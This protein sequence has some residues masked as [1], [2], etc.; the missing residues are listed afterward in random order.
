MQ[1]HVALDEAGFAVAVWHQVSAGR[2]SVWGNRL[3]P[4][5]GG[6]V[7]TLLETDD[8]GDASF[9]DVAVEKGGSATAVWMQNVSVFSIFASRFEPGRGWGRP[10]LIETDDAGHA[11]YPF[12]AVDAVGNAI[13]VWS[14]SDGTRQNV[15]ANRYA[16]AAGWGSATLLE[17]DNAGSAF[18]P[19]VAFDARGDAVVVWY[20]SDGTRTNIWANR[21]SVGAGWAAAELVEND[22]AG[23]AVDPQVALDPGGNAT[24]VWSQSDGTRPNIWA[25][26]YSVGSGWG[27]P[28]L[29]ETDNAGW[30]SRPSVGVDAS[31]VARVVWSQS[32]FF[33]YS[34]WTNRFV[35]GSGWGTRALVETL[36]SGDAYYPRI[37]VA[38]TGEAAAVWQQSDGT[39]E[40]IWANRFEPSGGWGQ[41]QLLEGDNG[42]R[43]LIP[44][45]AGNARGDAVAVW[46]Q[47]VAGIEHIFANA[48]TAADLTAPTLT[49]ESPAEGTL[50]NRSSLWV[51]GRTEPGALTSVN[52]VE[53]FVSAN[54]SFALT[55]PLAPG[56][57]TLTVA[58]RDAYGNEATASVNVTFD[59]PVPGLEARLRQA[60]ADLV[61]ART[62]LHA[63]RVQLAEAE[64]SGN[65]T[66]A[67]LAAAR[68]QFASA[69]ARAASLASDLNAT[70]A[71]L[72]SSQSDLHDATVRLLVV[73]GEVS[74]LQ[75]DLAA[76]RAREEELGSGLNLAN[77]VATAAVGLALGSLGVLAWVARSKG[78]AGGGNP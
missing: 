18:W 1:P 56:P 17:T 15:W 50:T 31:G 72:A 32:N 42:G 16:Q 41:A 55:V 54:G 40:N 71:G 62:D 46:Y 22:D 73:E 64:A 44:R 2:A 36:D 8:T 19:Q 45:V 11:Y 61:A 53:A 30:A 27:S 35:P 38:P 68:A 75:G 10:V 13:A 77:G 14:Q 33:R 63:T 7:P 66:E 29:V 65:A 58:A 59:D 69:E 49:L 34:I 5:V 70:R 20:Q 67:D 4:G 57:N 78:R 52:G 48:Y 76:A 21:Y 43:A 74:A 39:R 26:R 60:E 25:N 24:V 47:T 3:T 6:G 37:T 28:A 9:P 12:V 23:G 51:S